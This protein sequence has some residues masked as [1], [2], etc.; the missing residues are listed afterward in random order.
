LP[1]SSTPNVDGISEE[2]K[3]NLLQEHHEAMNEFIREQHF[4]SNRRYI[5]CNGAMVI[6]ALLNNGSIV[7][8]M[9]VRW[10]IFLISGL[11]QGIRD[12]ERAA[13]IMD[14]KDGPSDGAQQP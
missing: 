14:S 11:G 13:E 1:P 6:G 7:K 4:F 5:G 9:G 12:W 3:E 10:Q 2:Q 8:S